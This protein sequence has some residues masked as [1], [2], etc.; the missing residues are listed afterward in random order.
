MI[1]IVS[2]A[3]RMLVRYDCKPGMQEAERCSRYS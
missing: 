2:V 1:G 3:L